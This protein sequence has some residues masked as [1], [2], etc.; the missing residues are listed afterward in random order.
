VSFTEELA[1]ESMG[2]MVF[3]SSLI[4]MISRIF[5][6]KIKY[7]TNKDNKVLEILQTCLRLAASYMS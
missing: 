4:Y 3:A 6:K 7:S 2:V 5:S 1:L